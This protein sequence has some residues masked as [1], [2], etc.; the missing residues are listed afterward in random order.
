MG[1]T[2]PWAN[3]RIMRRG[4]TIGVATVVLV[5]VAVWVHGGYGDR[6]D[7]AG[8]LAD[9]LAIRPGMTVG[10]VGAGAGGW[11]VEMATRVGPRTRSATRSVP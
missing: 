2:M 6:G 8:R 7:D 11:T 1:S 4:L 9:A 3:G 10:E 5:S